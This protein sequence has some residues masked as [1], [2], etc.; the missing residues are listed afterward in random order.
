MPVTANVGFFLGPLLGGWL[1]DPAR[2]Y[3][4]LFGPVSAFGGR[5]G[6]LWM[7]KYPY[8]LPNL[9]TA[10]FLLC[11]TLLMLFTLEEVGMELEDQ[12]N[13]ANNHRRRISTGGTDKI[14][15]SKRANGCSVQSFGSS[16][17]CRPTNTPKSKSIMSWNSHHIC[18]QI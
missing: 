7:I 12:P 11:S 8:A 6:V 4:S 5:T 10:I 2:Q 16:G 18:P 14:V 1:Q 17:G 9:I 3:P 15:F 13:I